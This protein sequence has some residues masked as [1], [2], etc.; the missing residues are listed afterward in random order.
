MLFTIK[1]TVDLYTR[2]HLCRK[3]IH[4]HVT[5]ILLIMNNRSE[6]LN[7]TVALTCLESA[8]TSTHLIIEISTLSYIC[9]KVTYS[10]G[11]PSLLEVKKFINNYKLLADILVMTKIYSYVFNCIL[12]N[13]NK[14]K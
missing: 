7:V 6:R 2:F 3:C 12:I 13:I 14:W 9:H 10:G 5:C 8:F 1:Y 11:S 4:F